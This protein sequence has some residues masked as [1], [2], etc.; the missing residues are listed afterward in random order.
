MDR[1]SDKELPRIRPAAQ[2]PVDGPVHQH[3]PQRYYDSFPAGGSFPADGLVH[4]YKP[5]ILK[6]A[7]KYSRLYY[8]PH[9]DVVDKA[10]LIAHAAEEK[11]DP[12]RNT[13]FG[14]L[15]HWELLRLHRWCQ[16]QY[17]ARYPARRRTTRE[18]EREDW[19]KEDWQDWGREN[20]RRAA[21]Q[22]YEDSRA[23]ILSWHGGRRQRQDGRSYG[24]RRQRRDQGARH[25]RG[26]L[27]NYSAW[28]RACEPGELA[29]LAEAAARH[30]RHLKNEKQ[31][32]VLDWMV[33]DL[34]GRETR[35]MT[36]AA[37]D[38]GITKGYA[39][40]LVCEIARNIE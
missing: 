35:T 11:F 38:I 33:G 23:S 27:R 16:R 8:L 39:S 9:R 12:R 20:A 34:L 25:P 18:A 28:K 3:K 1:R 6:E 24:G 30:R 26:E 15:L 19:Q 22:Q 4:Q 7:L 13:S 2:S 37:F 32:A 5:F 14:T 36:Q 31:R 21:K 40:K 17:R 29:R 10:V